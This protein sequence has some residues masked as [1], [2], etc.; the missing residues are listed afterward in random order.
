MGKFR[1]TVETFFMETQIFRFSPE[2]AVSLTKPAV[3]SQEP[4]PDAADYLLEILTVEP[5][6]DCH[7]E[8]LDP[9]GT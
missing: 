6:E 4:T 1:A 5:D 8:P 7:G 3:A 2:T 9:V